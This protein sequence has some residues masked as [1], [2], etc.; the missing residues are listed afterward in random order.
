MPSRESR[1]PSFPS[2]SWR[3]SRSQTVTTATGRIDPTRRSWSPSSVSFRPR[4]GQ[5]RQFT[6]SELLSAGWGPLDCGAAIQPPHRHDHR[7]ADIAP[8]SGRSH[9]KQI[10]SSASPKRGGRT[11]D[12]IAAE[13]RVLV[14]GL[15]PLEGASG[16]VPNHSGRELHI[17]LWGACLRLACLR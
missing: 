15:V 14:S 3:G 8:M 10:R 5:A 6:A 12:R 11:H 7:I 2:L 9:I 17:R 13:V 16:D 1:G 4:T